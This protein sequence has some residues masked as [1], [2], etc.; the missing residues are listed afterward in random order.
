MKLQRSRERQMRRLKNSRERAIS[1]QAPRTG[2]GSEAIPQGSR[3]QEVSKRPAVLQKSRKYE[4]TFFM[5]NRRH[6][7]CVI[8]GQ[9][10]RPHMARGKCHRCY[11]AEYRAANLEKVTT[12]IE[13][14][15]QRNF[16]RL[17]VVNK[18]KR[19]AEHFDGKREAILK[20]DRYRCI[21]CKS[22]KQL[23]VH[24][25]DGNG[26]GSK[27]PN[28]SMQNLVTLC[29]ACHARVHGITDSWARDFNQ[30]QRCGTTERAHNAK[31]LCWKCYGIIHGRAR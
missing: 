23:V 14:W 27:Q 13:A 17:R 8:C 25:K 16:A 18:M 24:H 7:R 4:K 26:R 10:N 12:Q 22:E 29:R 28:N 3:D 20:R 9:T 11:L 2:E 31:G 6:E 21:E 30:C 15:R 1:S 19:E 5:W